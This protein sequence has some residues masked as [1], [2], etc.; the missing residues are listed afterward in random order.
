[1]TSISSALSQYSSQTEDKKTTGTTLADALSGTGSTSN[2]GKSSGTSDLSYL[3]NL[4]ETAKEYLANRPEI[5]STEKQASFVLSNTQQKT[6]NSIIEKYKDADFTQESF[7]AL[8]QELTGVGLGPDELAAKDQVSQI[9]PT[10]MFLNAL[11]GTD[12]GL[13]FSATSNGTQKAKAEAYIESI[14]TQWENISTTA[15]LES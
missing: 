12:G 9:N 14:Y 6:L 1:M 3:L 13:A 15:E 7:D 5:K 8:V 10:M 11:N 2:T 4:S